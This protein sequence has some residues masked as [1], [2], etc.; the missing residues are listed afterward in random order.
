MR[1]STSGAVNGE[2]NKEVRYDKEPSLHDYL[3]TAILNNL[4]RVLPMVSE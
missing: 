3:M 1:Y 2:E 4:E